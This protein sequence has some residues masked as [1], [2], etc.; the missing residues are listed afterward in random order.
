M[1]TSDPEY[2]DPVINTASDPA[3][4][5]QAETLAGIQSAADDALAAR[6]EALRKTI[7]TL[8]PE[9]TKLQTEQQTVWTWLTRGGVLIAFDLLV[10]ITGV[11]FGFYLHH[12]Q[13]ANEALIG[14]VKVNQERLNTSIHETCNLYS[15]FLGFY[16][17]ASKVRFIGG[18]VQYDKLYVTLQNSSDRLQCGTKHVVP[19]T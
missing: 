2:R 18:P 19:G 5:P 11:I 1:T 3:L 13:S 10:T 6:V 16:S 14:Q 15:T 4:S 9:V 17:D 7:A 12:V 8:S